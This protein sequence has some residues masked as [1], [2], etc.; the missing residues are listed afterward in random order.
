MMGVAI[1][2]HYIDIDDK[3]WYENINKRNEQVLA[4]KGGT[5]FYVDE[6]LLN[7]LK[8]KFEEPILDKMDIVYKR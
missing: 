8:S 4:G 3:T 5:S 6:G 1:E 7:K 2:W